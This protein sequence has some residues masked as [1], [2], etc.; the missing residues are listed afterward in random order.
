[1][2]HL[3]GKIKLIYRSLGVSIYKIEYH[4]LLFGLSLQAEHLNSTLNN[5]VCCVTYENKLRSKYSDVKTVSIFDML[6]IQKQYVFDA[7]SKHFNSF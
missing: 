5:M 7:L 3:R 4:N 2:L 6:Y 1:M